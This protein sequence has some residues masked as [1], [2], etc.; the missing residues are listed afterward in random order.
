MRVPANLTENQPED[1]DH[2]DGY[3]DQPQQNAFAHHHLPL[4]LDLGQMN[5]GQ[6]DCVPGTA[7]PDHA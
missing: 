2:G 7:R 6:A 3:A 4:S 5:E 1:D